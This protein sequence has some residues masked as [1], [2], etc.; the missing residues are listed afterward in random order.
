MTAFRLLQRREKVFGNL[1]NPPIDSILALAIAFRQDSRPQKID[2]GIGVYKNT[3]G[4][5]PVMR[6]VKA[7][8]KRV[9][10]TEK[11]KAY[12]GLA[13]DVGFAGHIQNLVLG[14]DFDDSRARSIQTVGGGA[15]VRLLCEVL[16]EGGA[17]TVWIPNPTWINH[18][19]I[20]EKTGLNVRRYTYLDPKTSTVDFDALC[21]DLSAAQSGDVVLLH[22]CCHNPSGADLS[23]DQW[24][25]L[26][27]LIAKKNLIPFVDIAYQG[28]GDGLDADAQ[29]LRVLAAAVPEL[30]I[31][32]SCSK[33][34]GVYRDRVG[35]AVVVGGNSADAEKAKAVL[36]A[37]GRVNYSFPANHGA[38]TV[39][40][41]FEDEK[42]LAD[43]REELETMR[44][45]LTATR[46]SLADALHD[47]TGSNRFDFVSGH[48]GMFSL[49]GLPPGAVERLRDEHAI[50]MPPDGRTNIAAI[51]ESDVQTVSKAIAEV[52]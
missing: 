6:A 22:A 4:D 19:P 8:E 50:F 49:L 35:T 23:V 44:L 27:E 15:A 24:K 45:R 17:T 52:L 43:W 25:S 51:K 42:L 18:V 29:G 31:S 20:S 2:L 34:F 21:S 28:F 14:K 38:A 47:A 5:T 13:G 39:A 16:V 41:I 33:N 12:I 9:W 10:E 3:N 26:T 36:L 1:P 32:A 30:V 46:A 48:K 11:S 40:A 37:M 7:A